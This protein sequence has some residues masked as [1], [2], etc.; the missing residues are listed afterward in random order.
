MI[1]FRSQNRLSIVGLPVLGCGATP[2]A[3]TAAA[4]K[5][6]HRLQHILRMSVLRMASPI[7][8]RYSA[9]DG[10][11][12]LSGGAG[13]ARRSVFRQPHVDVR[14]VLKILWT[15]LRFQSGGH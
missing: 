13:R 11:H 5:R 10:F 12:L 7:L 15:E 4:H 6:G 14:K 3:R 1:V 9:G 8:V 2:E